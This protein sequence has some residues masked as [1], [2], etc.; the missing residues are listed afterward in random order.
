MNRH[1]SSIIFSV[2][3]GETIYAEIESKTPLTTFTYQVIAHGKI[4][5]AETVAVPNREYH[6]IEFPATFDMAPT[7]RLLVYHFKDN[8]I[9]STHT[10]ITLREDLNNFIKVKVSSLKA[11]PGSSVDIDV[12]TKPHSY[13]GLLG[14]DQ[15][16]L[17]LKANE[18]LNKEDA[19]NEIEQYQNAVH[20]PTNNNNRILT[21]YYSNSYWNDFRVSEPFPFIC[22]ANFF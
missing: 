22:L 1:F 15:S 14:V 17:L 10:D 21:P 3:L 2:T 16:V 20:E 5:R 11:K 18:E 13:V 9:Q 4:L 6:V 12:S 19:F 8:E 7:A